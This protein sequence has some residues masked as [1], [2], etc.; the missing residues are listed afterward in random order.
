M[1]PVTFLYN[2]S[3]PSDKDRQTVMYEFSANGAHM[4]KL[5]GTSVRDSVELLNRIADLRE[6]MGEML[7]DLKFGHEGIQQFQCCGF[8][9]PDEHNELA[10]AVEHRPDSRDLSQARFAGAPRHRQSEQAA[11]QNRR[12]D[13]MNGL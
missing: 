13:F 7:V 4:V 5:T 2:W 12:L 11:L 10:V 1:V 9:G 3:H 8:R 6:I